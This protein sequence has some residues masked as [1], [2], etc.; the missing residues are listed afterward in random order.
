MM[1]IDTFTDGQACAWGRGKDVRSWPHYAGY[2]ER[3][4]PAPRR[5]EAD[6][7]ISWVIISAGA[8]YRTVASRGAKTLNRKCPSCLSESISVSGLILSDVVCVNC[9]QLVGVHWLFRSV[10]FVVILVATLFTV[11]VVL[12]NQGLYAAL[13]MFS[14]PIGAIGFIKARYCPLVIKRQRPDHENLR[15]D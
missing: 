3:S 11:F 10:F 6:H 7:R 12:V 8:P 1:K 4:C 2:P 9:G 13:L 5:P 15:L 14:V